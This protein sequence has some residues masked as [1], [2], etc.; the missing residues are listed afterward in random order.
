MKG[1]GH[2]RVT[3]TRMQIANLHA[4]T[5]AISNKTLRAGIW[6]PSLWNPKWV[7]AATSPLIGLNCIPWQKEPSRTSR[8]VKFATNSRT[9]ERRSGLVRSNPLLRSH[10]RSRGICR[11]A[12]QV[13]CFGEPIAGSLSIAFS[14]FRSRFGPTILQVL[15]ACIF[16]T[17][18]SCVEAQNFQI[19]DAK[20]QGM[21]RALEG[22]VARWQRHSR[23]ISCPRFVFSALT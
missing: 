21:P 8:K 1:A 6:R 11:A 19:L 23:Q 2:K 10:S 17:R 4:R 13:C 9:F 15:D 7:I 22:L 3:N 12:S 20:E 18:R 14:V 5:L 16:L